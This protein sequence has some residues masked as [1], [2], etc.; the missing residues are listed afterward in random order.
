MFLLKLLVFSDSHGNTAN[1]EK[2]IALERPDQI[3]HLGDGYRDIREIAGR[4][5]QIPVACVAGNCDGY[6]CGAEE[7]R[8]LTIAG[9]VILMTHG[10][11][12]QVKRGLLAA[13]CAAREAGA[14]ILLYGHTHQALCQKD[15]GLWILNPGSIRDPFRPSYGLILLDGERTECA[16][17]PV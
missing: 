8:R 15:G 9:R 10:H 13:V 5:P 6:D 16:V 11:R 2:T 3:L 1:M 14:N 7:E 12:Y 17:V 4:F